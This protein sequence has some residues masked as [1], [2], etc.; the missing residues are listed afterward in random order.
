MTR[1]QT[2]LAVIGIALHVAIVVNLWHAWELTP[3]VINV[4]CP[5]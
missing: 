1:K 3:R 2:V 5:R 4:E